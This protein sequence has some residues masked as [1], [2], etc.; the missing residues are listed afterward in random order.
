MTGF[1]KGESASGGIRVAVEL[2]SVNNRFCEFQF[3]LPKF[4]SA[5][6]PKLKEK[7]SQALERGKINYALTWEDE[8]GAATYAELNEE[9]ADIYHQLLIRLKKRFK[10][11]GKITLSDFTALPDLIK[12]NREEVPDEKAWRLIWGATEK[13]LAQLVAMRKSEGTLLAG[14]LM[15]RI[16]RLN[17]V[18]ALIRGLAEGEVTSYRT[19]LKNRITELLGAPPVDEQRI[20][21]EVAL[22]AEK[23]DVTEEC[24]RFLAHNQQFLAA[25]EENVAVGRRL[26]FLLQEMNREA[27]TIGSKSLSA[28]IV[29]R[30][31]V[32]K[33]EIEK[34][35][36]QVQN[37][38]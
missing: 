28:E 19:R 23:S 18:I 12:L 14:E 20:A 38:Q 29:Q 6:E 36:E 8:R 33:E 1:G 17:E 9:A 3:R 2:S 16:Q 7:L 24:V 27:N 11:S 26:N 5:W 15:G 34:L 4:L 31:V 32:L 30:V 35:R 13:A 21:L 22:L 25:L 10:I 37:I